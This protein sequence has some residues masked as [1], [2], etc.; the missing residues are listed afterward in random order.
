MVLNTLE[1]ID[2]PGFFIIN[3]LFIFSELGFWRVGSRKFFAIPE[4]EYRKDETPPSA[5]KKRKS[6]TST[7]QSDSAFIEEAVESLV[8]EVREVKEETGKIRELAFRHEFSLSFIQCL[9]KHLDA[10]FAM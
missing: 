1:G 9:K 10:Q 2:T 6:C 4:T 3:C 5:K 7:L 8:E